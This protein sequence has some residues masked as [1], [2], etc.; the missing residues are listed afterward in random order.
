MRVMCQRRSKNQ[1]ELA[2]AEFITDRHAQVG[3]DHLL[4]FEEFDAVERFFE[5]KQGREVRFPRLNASYH[6]SNMSYGVVRHNWSS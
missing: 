2:Q 1:P 5:K 6:L 4:P 3:I